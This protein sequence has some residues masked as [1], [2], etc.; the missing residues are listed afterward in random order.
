M[1]DPT[2][3]LTTADVVRLANVLRRQIKKLTDCPRIGIMLPS[4]VAFAG[5]FYGALWA[6]RTAIPLNFLLQP[7]EL[8][9][10]VRDSGINTIIS[11]RHFEEMLRPLPVRS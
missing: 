4:T 1:R 11:I 9:S 6:G 3:E 7:A 10:V 2:R 8:A 5:T